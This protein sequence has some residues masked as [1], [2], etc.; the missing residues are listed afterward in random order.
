MAKKYYLNRP[1]QVSFD[2]RAVYERFGYTRYK[3]S[4]FEEYDLYV[5][6]GDSL[7]SEG[8]ITF[9]DLSGKLMA[10]K[11]DVTLS[12]IKNSRNQSG[13]QK[14]Y[15]DEKVYRIPKGGEAYKEI[16]QV[17]L[18]CMGDIDDYCLAEVV[19]LAG[20]SL[21]A[22]GGGVLDI[23]PMG[24]TGGI[25]EACD[26]SKADR[27][28]IARC[29]GEKN[30]HELKAACKRAGMDKKHTDL[31]CKVAPLYGKPEEIIPTLKKI[32]PKDFLPVVLQLETL[33]S[34]LPIEISYLINIDFSAGTDFGYYNGLVFKGYCPGCPGA[35]LSGGQYDKLMKKMGRKGS[36]IGFAVYPDAL[37]AAEEPAFDTDVLLVYSKDE[38]I[39]TVAWA[40]EWLRAQGKSVD[41]SCTR[42]SKKRFK[43]IWKLENKEV[44]K[45]EDNA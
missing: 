10:L 25:M 4:K 13:V 11:P 9:T 3:M 2:L 32:L 34:T 37:E 24:I 40:C 23:C 26:I 8:V 36:A 42:K 14:V 22:I 15:Y 18:E 39:T 35:V 6:Y 16:S 29:I 28:D 19:R 45:L 1:E 41:A 20:E 33:L 17:G 5:R 27:K 21:R 12:I 7:I 31:L 43:E 38:D 30:S 44:R